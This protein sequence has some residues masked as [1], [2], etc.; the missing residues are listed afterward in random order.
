VSYAGRLFSHQHETL[1]ALKAAARSDVPG[2]VSAAQLRLGEHIFEVRDKGAGL[3][4]FVL[5][6]NA[7]RISLASFGARALPMAYV[8]ISSHRLASRPVE[9]IEAELRSLLA[10]L[11]TLEGLARVSRIDLFVDFVSDVDIESWGRAS[12]VTRARSINAYAVDS[13]F[14]GWAIGLGGPM[15]A[16][17]YDKT[18][19]LA[20]SG[21]DWLKPLWVAGGWDGE[22]RVLRLEFEVKRDTLK[23]LGLE[24]LV[25]VLRTLPGLWRYATTEWLRLA[26]ANPDDATRSRWPI[27]PLWSLLSKIDWAGDPGPLSR[28]FKVERAPSVRWVLRQIFALLCS[29][30]A[31]RG[32]YNYAQGLDLLQTELSAFLGERSEREFATQTRIVHDQVALKMRRF[33]TGYNLDEI[34]EEDRL[35]E[36][37][38]E[39]LRQADAYRKAS[40]GS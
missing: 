7:Y 36:Q 40:R 38:D 10:E 18:L 39:L 24:V 32:L 11:G 22:A 19:E 1:Q 16:R 8:K 20:K 37:Q 3:F 21:K 15:A 31:I 2:E 4:A 34:S 17:L 23:G 28:S 6:D 5:E 12:W 29:F 30:M 14:S 35:Q 26:V 27:H 9:A 33:N 13:R 25:D